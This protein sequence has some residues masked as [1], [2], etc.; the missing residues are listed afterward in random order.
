MSFFPHLPIAIPY[1]PGVRA[2]WDP[3]W[4]V[5]QIGVMTSLV[6]YFNR[7]AD[8]IDKERDG[9]PTGSPKKNNS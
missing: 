6:L 4:W 1:S 9:T 3:F 7:L 5:F 2:W 8:R